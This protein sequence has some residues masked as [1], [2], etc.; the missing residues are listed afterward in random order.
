[1]NTRSI[2]TLNSI[3]FYIRLFVIIFSLVEFIIY[4]YILDYSIGSVNF[5]FYIPIYIFLVSCFIK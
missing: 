4:L 3:Y 5:K 1:M 2:K